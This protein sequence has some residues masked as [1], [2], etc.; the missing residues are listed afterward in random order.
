MYFSAKGPDKDGIYH[1]DMQVLADIMMGKVIAEA[2]P[3][4]KVQIE[5][6]SGYKSY[7]GEAVRSGAHAATSAFA[8]E[9]Y[10]AGD[11]IRIAS[12]QPLGEDFRLTLQGQEPQSALGGLRDTLQAQGQMLLPHSAYENGTLAGQKY[13]QG[14]FSDPVPERPVSSLD[15]LLSGSDR[16]SASLMPGYAP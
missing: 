14:Y 8:F 12:S 11:T 7:I 10:N 16:R 9:E 3:L 6:P 15:N 1:Y 2:G 13:V 4:V 5:S